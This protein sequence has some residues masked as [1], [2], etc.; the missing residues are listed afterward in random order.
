MQ[1]ASIHR[2]RSLINMEGKDLEKLLINRVMHHIY[3]NNFMNLI[4]MDL[5]PKKEYNR[6]HTIYERMH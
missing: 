2:L 5:P 3:R 6:C 4:N 1:D